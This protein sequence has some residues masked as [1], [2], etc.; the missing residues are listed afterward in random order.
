[1]KINNHKA[2]IIRNVVFII[3][4][5]LFSISSGIFISE[6]HLLSGGMRTF[7]LG[8]SYFEERETENISVS[9]NIVF[10][11]FAFAIMMDLN[12]SYNYWVMYGYGSDG[13]L[14]EWH[15]TYTMNGRDNWIYWC[16]FEKEGFVGLLKVSNST[17][18]VYEMIPIGVVNIYYGV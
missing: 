15:H 11:G 6:N 13:V 17:I 4:T 2:I 3:F 14:D 10:E 18:N 1:M 16:T 8:V 5:V 12:S 7:K 9:S